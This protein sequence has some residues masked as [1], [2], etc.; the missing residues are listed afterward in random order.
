MCVCE[1]ERERSI[2]HVIKDK[3]IKEK[4]RKWRGVDYTKK[5]N[6]ELIECMYLRRSP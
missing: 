6:K 3:G 5:G 1:R 2:L 4:E